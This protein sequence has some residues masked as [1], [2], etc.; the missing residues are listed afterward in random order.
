MNIFFSRYELETGRPL[1][2]LSY[3]SKREGALLKIVFRE[4]I[5]GYADCH[6]WEELGD[7]PL[8]QQLTLLASEEW[9]P[10]TRS[11]LEWS[12][13]DAEAR[14]A[15]KTILNRCSIPKSHWLVPDLHLLT[16]ERVDEITMQGFTHVKFKLGRHIEREGELLLTLFKGSSLMLRLDCNE[17]LTCSAF[18]S[19]LKQIERL[20]PQVDFIEDPFPFHPNEWRVCQQQGWRL[21]CDRQALRAKNLPSSAS[22]LIVKPAIHSL[23][24]WEKPEG[25]TCIVTSYLGHPLGQTAAA[26]AAA[27]LDPQNRFVHGLLSHHA[28]LPTPFSR[29]LSW[30]G[31]MFTIP[32]GT[33]FGFDRELN[34]LAWSSIKR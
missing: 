29:Q 19:F 17:A 30:D 22:V 8:Q 21:A 6:A 9:T 12:K 1:N 15:G 4:G 18:H 26:Y 3:S 5:T 32:Q 25:Q 16:A 31:P 11:A 7:R 28:Y 14:T 24:A 13:R 10:I 20:Q 27:V 2:A 33:G 34:E 23:D